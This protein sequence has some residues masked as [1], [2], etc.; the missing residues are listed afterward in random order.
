M[1]QPERRRSLS[2]HDLL[3]ASAHD[4]DLPIL[5]SLKP[6]LVAACL[7]VLKLLPARYIVESATR[8][9]KLKRGGEVVESTS[10]TFGLALAMLSQEYGFTATLVSDPVIDDYLKDRLQGYGARLEIIEQIING[11]YQVARIN[12]VH[13]ILAK[14][15]DAY[16]TNQYHNPENPEG[17][18]KLSRFLK[19]ELGTIDVLVGSV[20]TGGSMCG[21]ARVLKRYNPDLK[22]IGIDTHCSVIFGH[23]SSNRVLRGLGNSLMPSNV[24]HSV[25]DEVHW[26]SAIDAYNTTRWLESVHGLHMGGTSGAAH[27]V[28]DWAA[29]VHPHKNVVTL[30]PDDGLRY[31]H[32]IYNDAYLKSL[33]GYTDAIPSAPRTVE[34]ARDELTHWSRL[35][36]KQG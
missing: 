9:G 25:F 11:G 6:N 34:H 13:E 33:P 21:T 12:K 26:V 3:Y 7:S 27:L 1:Q 36:L 20:S 15:P 32:T 23:Q 31:R 16:F 19:A 8:R 4:I 30:F 17:Y 35:I 28:A 10:G 29:R 14:T 2:A 5:V 18:A 24:D 22:V